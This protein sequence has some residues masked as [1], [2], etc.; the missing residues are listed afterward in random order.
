MTKVKVQFAL[1]QDIQTQGGSTLGI[2]GSF[3]P[4]LHYPRG[5]DPIPIVQEAGWATGGQFTSVLNSS[6]HFWMS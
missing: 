6:D 2:S 5:T 3:S 4:L 1:E